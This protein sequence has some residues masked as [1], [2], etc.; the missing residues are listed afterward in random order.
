MQRWRTLAAAFAGAPVRRGAGREAAPA[1]CGAAGPPRPLSWRPSHL[2]AWVRLTTAWPGRLWSQCS[3]PF[4]PAVCCLP[5]GTS[6]TPLTNRLPVACLRAAYWSR[7]A[8]GFGTPASPTACLRRTSGRGG[9][10]FR[11]SRQPMGW[12]AE[13]GLAAPRRSAAA[14]RPRMTELDPNAFRAPSNRSEPVQAKPVAGDPS[15]LLG[16]FRHDLEQIAD[17]ADVR[18]LEDRCVLVLIDGDD[19]LG[20]LHSGEVLDRARNADRDID[21]RCDDLAGLADLVVVRRIARIDRC[22]RSTDGR[23]E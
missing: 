8:P 21:V 10:C 11:H 9:N 7:L 18:D 6:P 23:P 4:P 1:A 20:I 5:A 12:T 14:L 15:K 3:P 16:Q 19:R 13:A 17:Q 22:A 2:A